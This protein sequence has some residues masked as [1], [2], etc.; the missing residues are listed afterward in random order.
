YVQQ[1]LARLLMKSNHVD[2]CARLC[3]SSSVVA[4]MASL[5]SGATSNSYADYEDAGCLMVVGSDPNSNHP[6]VGAR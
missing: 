5:G 3:H 2:H 6:V 1:K 4:M